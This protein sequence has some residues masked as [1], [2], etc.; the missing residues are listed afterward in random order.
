MLSGINGDANHGGT[1]RHGGAFV[2]NQQTYDLHGRQDPE[3]GIPALIFILL[4]DE[5]SV[6][7]PVDYESTMHYFDDYARYI[8]S[9]CEFRVLKR[10]YCFVV[11]LH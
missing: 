2:A 11:N 3:G 10:I 4:N 8:V 1:G 6:P 5:P 9:E 7:H